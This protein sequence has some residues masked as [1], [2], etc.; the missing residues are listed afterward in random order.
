MAR[1]SI[2]KKL[3]R[4]RPPRVQISYDVQVG[5]AIEMK[6]LPFV[7]GVIGDF[8]GQPT[9]PLGPIE[10]PPLCRCDSRKFR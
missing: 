7:M 4:V 8:T 3:T 2:Q 1:E 6:E 10:R 5:D 9:E